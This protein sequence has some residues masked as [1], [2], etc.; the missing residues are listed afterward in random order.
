MPSGITEEVAVAG[1]S[2][3]IQNKSAVITQILPKDVLC[4]MQDEA[5]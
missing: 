3:T 4:D 2:S 5:L 1:K